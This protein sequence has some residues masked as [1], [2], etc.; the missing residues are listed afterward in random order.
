M[1]R[2][3]PS[4]DSTEILALG[5]SG[6]WSRSCCTL[7]WFTSPPAA[8]SS[9][10]VNVYVPS[11]K[12]THTHAHVLNYGVGGRITTKPTLVAHIHSDIIIF[13]QKLLGWCDDNQNTTLTVIVCTSKKIRLLN[14]TKQ[15]GGVIKIQKQ[16]QNM[17]SQFNTLISISLINSINKPF[18]HKSILNQK[19]L[20]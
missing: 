15:Q 10:W 7:N 6:F 20:K 16:N 19:H 11:G 9:S 4:S 2:C 8:P 3:L 17:I 18:N 5:S 12:S 1:N 14:F 13:S